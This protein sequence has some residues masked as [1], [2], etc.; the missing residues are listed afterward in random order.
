MSGRVGVL[1]FPG[2]NSEDETQRAC[3]AVGLVAD[4]VHWSWDEERTRGFDA[5]ILPGGFAYEDRVRAGAIAAHDRLMLAVREAA[6]AGK[7]VLG[8]CNGAQVLLESGLVPALDGRTARPQAAFAKNAP[9][10]KYRSTHVHV[11]LAIPPERCSITASLAP[12]TVLPAWASHGEGRLAA[13]HEVLERIEREGRVAFAYCDAQGRE[14]AE[15]VPNGSA[16]GAAGLVNDR[17]NVLALM[18]HPERDAW[19][20]MHAGGARAA[21]W[22]DT[23]A[24]LAPSGGMALFASL[25]RALGR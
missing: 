21:A 23:P 3:Q 7:P 25:A 15:A 19:T 4:L 2:T 17:G 10:G 12:D 6:E 13:Q 16:L 22:G 18:P 14:T 5:Y 8:I 9:L 24:T 1:V 11:K 20:F